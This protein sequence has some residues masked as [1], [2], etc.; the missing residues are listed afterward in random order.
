MSARR[1]FRPPD[2]ITRPGT[3]DSRRRSKTVVGEVGPMGARRHI[4][5]P[6]ET[7]GLEPHFSCGDDS[8]GRNHECCSGH[9]HETA[10]DDDH[11]ILRLLHEQGPALLQAYKDPHV[12]FLRVLSNT[13]QHHAPVYGHR[14]E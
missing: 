6:R 7:L 9:C 2:D 5:G 8:N 3:T 11:V 4:R 10:R 1:E 13:Y 12:D 14:H